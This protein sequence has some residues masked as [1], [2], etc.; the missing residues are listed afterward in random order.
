MSRRDDEI[1]DEL[2]AHL[3]M[4]IRDRIERG[5]DP[6]EAEAA[7]RREFG[8]A[9]RVAEDTRSVWV[10]TWLESVGQDLR[11]AARGLRR[12]PG[13]TAVAVL[14]LALGI[15]ANTA[16]FTILN[17]VVLKML[18][19]PAPQELVELLQQYPGEPRGNGYWSGESYE[20]F[21]SSNRS[22]ASLAGF[23][24][25]NRTQVSI[26]GEPFTFMANDHV[27]PNFFAMLGLPVALSEGGVIVSGRL[28]HLLGKQIQVDGKAVTVTGV[29]PE[30]FVGM[31]TGSPTDL[32]TVRASDAK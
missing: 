21:R 12:S 16:I 5:E 9:L 8:S 25:D 22:F 3:N 28:R 17:A 11:Y 20:H 13:F 31:L 18:P 6:R 30:G 29:A 15:G 1:D 4:A 32:W 23:A 2:R 10:W 14:S 7:A 27:T 24:R 26:D 19:L